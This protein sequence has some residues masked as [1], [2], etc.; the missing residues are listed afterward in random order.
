MFIPEQA[1]EMPGLES[2]NRR[3]MAGVGSAMP[4]AS[5]S[6]SDEQASTPPATGHIATT[7]TPSSTA[8]AIRGSYWRLIRL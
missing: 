7:P 8:L 6:T 1:V 2:T 4:I 3:L 5:W